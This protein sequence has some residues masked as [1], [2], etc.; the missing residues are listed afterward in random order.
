MPIPR[1]FDY[2]LSEIDDLFGLVKIK[3]GKISR[4]QFKHTEDGY[5][6]DQGA[7][8]RDIRELR[9]VLQDLA[10]K[11]MALAHEGANA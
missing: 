11:A 3:L 9:E 6:R 7:S 10:N 5:V 2:K 1:P 8:E 4:G